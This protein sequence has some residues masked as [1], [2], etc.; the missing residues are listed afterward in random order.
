MT[1]PKLIAFYFPQFHSI[2]ENDKWWG[3]GFNDWLLVQKNKPVYRDHRQPR[4]PLDND[5]YNPCD[6]NTLK[7]QIDQAKEYGVGGFMMYHYWFDGKLMLET[8]LETFLN[9]KDLDMPFCI[10][11]ANETWSRAWIGH[12]EDILIK[13]MHTPDPNIWRRHFEYLYPFLEDERS[14]KINGKPMILIYQPSLI[15]EGERMI[16]HWRKWANEKGIGDLYVVAV[17][18]HERTRP[19]VYLP[20]DAI[21]KFQPRLAMNS[22]EFSSEKFTNRFSFLRSLPEGILSYISKI[23]SRL[24]SYSLFD[25]KKVWDIILKHAYERQSGNEKLDIYESA[26]FE[27]D[28]S[29]RYGKKA[30]IFTRLEDSELTVRLQK[31]YDKAVLVNSPYIFFNA[32]NEWSESA[33]LE[34]DKDLGYA[35]LNI[36]KK[37]FG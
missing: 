30:K 10:C 14:I 36:V 29:A 4:V 9:N 24:F 32:W 2:P 27:W 1:H 20:Y 5:Y 34:P 21:L 22:P 12:P 16:E 7:K 17:K 23:Y 37:I 15:I 26:Y 28:N 6:Y 33:Y 8:P 35:N 25:S 19:E 11:W 3:K 13:Q 31:L 18:G